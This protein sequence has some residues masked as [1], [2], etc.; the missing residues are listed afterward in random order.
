[1]LS[2]AEALQMAQTTKLIKTRNVDITLRCALLDRHEEFNRNSSVTWWFK[3]T[4][5]FSCWDK[6][7]NEDDEWNE[8]GCDGPCRTSL[9]LNDENVSNGFYQCRIFPYHT[10]NQTVLQIEVMKTFQIEIYGKTADSNQISSLTFLVSRPNNCP[11]TRYSRRVAQRIFNAFGLSAR[12]P[13][14]MQK[15]P[16]A[17]HQMVP[18]E[19]RRISQVR[20]AHVWVVQKLHRESMVDQVFRELLRAAAVFRAERAQ[21]SSLLEQANRQQHNSKQHLRLRSNKLLRIL[22]QG[23]SHKSTA[24]RFTRGRR[25]RVFVNE[26]SWEELRN[27]VPDSHPPSDANIRAKLHYSLPP[28]L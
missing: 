25:K 14:Q 8:V 11:A 13:V 27:H 1:M 9:L 15:F 10:S 26:L 22:L 28:N 20:W 16:E 24:R 23:K 7:A 17:D 2:T 18:K 5:K 4:C 6:P 19:G 12:S 3:R 21:R